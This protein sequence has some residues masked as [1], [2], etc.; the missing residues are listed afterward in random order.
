MVLHD[1]VTTSVPSLGTS[2][3]K[4]DGYPLQ[5]ALNAA[6]N[7]ASNEY[8]TVYVSPPATITNFPQYI[9]NYPVSVPLQVNIIWGCAIQAT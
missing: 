2:I 7:S 3:A 1:N 9:I 6:Y 4:D 5:L 8:G